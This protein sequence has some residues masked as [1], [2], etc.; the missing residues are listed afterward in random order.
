M[1]H[2]EYSTRIWLERN[3]Y[4][5]YM[6]QTGVCMKRRICFSGTRKAVEFVSRKGSFGRTDS[7]G[8]SALY[9]YKDKSPPPLPSD[10]VELAPLSPRVAFYNTIPFPPEKR[11]GGIFS[12]LAEHVM[13]SHIIPLTY[14]K[15]SVFNI[16][17]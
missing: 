8:A 11:A 6:I 14:V 9:L 15:H 5:I 16:E 12:P 2:A 3:A 7:I 1:L 4:G 10:N 13:Q 17:H